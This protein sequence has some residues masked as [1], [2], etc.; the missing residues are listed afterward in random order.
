MARPKSPE[1]TERELEVMH[2][3]WEADDAPLVA[4]SG[5]ARV[6]GS[7]PSPQDATRPRKSTSSTCGK[8]GIWTLL[9][10]P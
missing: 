1:L 10:E 8:L 5:T 2:V 9:A 6:P 4:G 7:A 3:F